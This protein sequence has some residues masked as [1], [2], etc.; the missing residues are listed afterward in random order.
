[1]NVNLG[2]PPSKRDC[3][4]VTQDAADSNRLQH[5]Q[6]AF[7]QGSDEPVL[8]LCLVTVHTLPVIT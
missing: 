3:C 6:L 1:M 4:Y 7:C 8:E 5:V 2:K